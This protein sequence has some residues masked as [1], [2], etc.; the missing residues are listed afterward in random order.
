MGHTERIVAELATLDEA[1]KARLLAFV[2]ELKAARQLSAQ[3]RDYRAT[4]S[5]ALAPY[6]VRLADFR[7][8]R[9]DANAR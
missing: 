9:E 8:D 7:F 4:Q 5:A 3:Q 6:R 2:H 1:E